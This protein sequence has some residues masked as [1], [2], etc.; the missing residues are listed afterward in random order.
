MV[1]VFGLDPSLVADGIAD[2]DFVQIAH[3]A[4]ASRPGAHVFMV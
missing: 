3:Q 4:I 1:V 2:A